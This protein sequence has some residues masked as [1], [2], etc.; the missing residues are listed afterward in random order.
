VNG[1]IITESGFKVEAGKDIVKFKGKILDIRPQMVYILLNKPVDTLTTVV[2]HRG[3]K[4]VRDLIEIEERIFP[5]GR[6]DKDTTGVL[7]LTNDGELAY[8]LAHPKFEVTKIYRAEVEGKPDSRLISM[9]ARGVEIEKGVVVS[10]EATIVKTRSETSCVEIIIHEGKKRQ[11]KKMLGACG[12]PVLK[13]ERICF[14]EMNIGSLKAGK[15][16][17]LTKEEVIMLYE[18][19]GLST[20]NEK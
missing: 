18:Q 15:W 16:R 14:A 4:T 7:I 9:L 3:R 6:L 19:V 10:G 2:D 8:R 5:I 20:G 17:E 13:L 1:K 11:V 12:Y